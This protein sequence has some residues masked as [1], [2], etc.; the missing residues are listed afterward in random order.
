MEKKWPLSSRSGEKP[1]AT[2]LTAKDR[3]QLFTGKSFSQVDTPDYFLTTV[4]GC[5][6]VFQQQRATSEKIAR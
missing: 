2:E 6:D 5:T 4:T 1:Y 3:S